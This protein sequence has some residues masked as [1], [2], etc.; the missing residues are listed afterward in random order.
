MKARSTSVA[1]AVATVLSAGLA[2]QASAGI[3]A[4]SY[5]DIDDLSIVIS[6]NGGV[7]PGGAIPNNFQFFLT[8]T[9]SLNFLPPVIG[10]ASCSGSPGVP[11]PT[12]NNCNPVLN[13]GLP[14][15]GTALDAAPAVLGAPPVTGLANNLFLYNGPG[16]GEYSRSD[17]VIRTAQLAAG[18]VSS[19]EQIAESELQSGTSAAAS[20]EIQ[21]LTGFT[22]NFTVTGA[23]QIQIGFNADSSRFVQINDL[24]AA[25]A[26]A[27]ANMQVEFRLENDST[28]DFVI[29][30]PDGNV[31]T[32]VI[33][34]FGAEVEVD[35]FDLQSDFG[36]SATP[37]SCAGSPTPVCP[38]LG[39][40][41]VGD[42]YNF[43]FTGLYNGDWTLTLSALTST[44][45]TR[46]SQVPEPASLALVG[47][48]LAGL[49][50]A[51]RR[52]KQA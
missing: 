17:S 15:P 51:S 6:D 31:G 2:D 43:L 25:T 38:S 22:F 30:R 18:T 27:Q 4:R 16:S 7:S 37:L 34:S 10:A 36:V 23:N 29:W 19:T 42:V 20:A 11:G 21:S 14:T 28:G 26:G 50:F 49:G 45:V 41:S 48:A 12:T 1:V 24:L 9:A 40:T 35:P 13:N 52:R 8:N 39:L 32:G 47:M 3:Y 5:L 46:T 44:S 33:K